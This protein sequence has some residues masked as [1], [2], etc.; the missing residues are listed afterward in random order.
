[1]PSVHTCAALL[2][3]PNCWVPG[4]LQHLSFAA[5][6]PPTAY[7]TTQPV[8]TAPPIQHDT[9]IPCHSLPYTKQGWHSVDFN[10]QSTVANLP[11]PLLPPSAAMSTTPSHT[12]EQHHTHQPSPRAL[13]A[14]G[15]PAHRCFS[16]TIPSPCSC[17]SSALHCCKHA[18]GS[19][20]HAA[21]S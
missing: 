13:T 6:H 8:F 7:C 10:M 12:T 1:M 18:P 15:S 20:F 16:C 3:G 19:A 9:Y 5:C 17:W 21:A 14:A 11:H 2:H 4:T